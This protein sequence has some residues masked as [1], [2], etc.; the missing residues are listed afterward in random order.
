YCMAYSDLITLI[1]YSY[2]QQ[3]RKKAIKSCYTRYKQFTLTDRYLKQPAY[4]AKG[5]IN[6][7]LQSIL[8]KF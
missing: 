6:N 7:E 4:S 8:V 5:L 1:S 3:D 2:V